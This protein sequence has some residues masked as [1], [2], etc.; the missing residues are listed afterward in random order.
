MQEQ[1]NRIAQHRLRLGIAKGLA[2]QSCQ[3]V[4]QATVLAL[5]PRHRKFTDQMIQIINEAL[6]DRI[7]IGDVEEAPPTAHHQPQLPE[8]RST[9]VSQYPS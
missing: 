5:N 1:P 2:V 6:V 3:I 8:G 7:A 9:A 4:P